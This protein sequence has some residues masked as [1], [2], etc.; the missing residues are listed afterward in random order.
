MYLFIS[1]TQVNEKHLWY[2]ETVCTAFR[3]I[4]CINGPN[5]SGNLTVEILPT[6]S[7]NNYMIC[8]RNAICNWKF[9]NLIQRFAIVIAEF[10]T[11]TRQ[12]SPAK[13]RQSA[14]K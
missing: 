6:R 1:T 12:R 8:K 13:K 14:Q 11:L 10:F 7:T 9:Y 5:V 3:N 4:I 2:R